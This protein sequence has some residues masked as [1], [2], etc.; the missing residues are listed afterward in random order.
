[1]NSTGHECKLQWAPETPPGEYTVK[2]GI[3]YWETGER[4][5]VWDENWERVQDDAVL[6]E[7]II[8]TQ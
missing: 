2:I 1:M 5:P 6:L 7:P 4:L 3:Y 8:V